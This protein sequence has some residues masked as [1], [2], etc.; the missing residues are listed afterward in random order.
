[1][2]ELEEI[3][4]HDREG[5]NRAE[6]KMLQDFRDLVVAMERMGEEVERLLGRVEA[7]KGEMRAM[8]GGCCKCEENR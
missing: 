6:R 8:E 2:F 5:G 1:M 4:E 3:V 7:R